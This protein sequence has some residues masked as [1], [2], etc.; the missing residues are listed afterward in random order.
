[1]AEVEVEVAT[2][3]AYGGAA[4]ADTHLAADI[5]AI[6][7]EIY[8]V[9]EAR[10]S[11]SRTNEGILAAESDAA[12]AYRGGP[13]ILALTDEQLERLTDA[14]ATVL[15]EQRDT[16]LRA[17]AS[18]LDGAVDDAELLLAIKAARSMTST[19]LPR[20]RWCREDRRPRRH[21]Q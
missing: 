16:F 7:G 18:H 6:D 4:E 15:R 20:S 2:A 5:V 12:A 3:I 21:R 14:A 8:D 13:M 9:L 17:V 19:L 11:R 1:M 10:R